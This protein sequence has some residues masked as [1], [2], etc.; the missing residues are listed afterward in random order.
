MGF[1]GLRPGLVSIVL[2]FVVLINIDAY[3]LAS[4][5]REERQDGL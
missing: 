5:D 3:T 1:L 2:Q 4:T